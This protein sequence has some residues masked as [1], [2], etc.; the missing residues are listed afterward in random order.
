MRQQ[1][2]VRLSTETRQAEIIGA[3]LQLAAERSPAL[4]TTGDIAKA[5]S[6]TQG[7]V[8]R[9]FPTKDAIWL[10]VIDWV[11][12]NLLDSLEA[13]AQNAATPLAGLQ[14]VF[15]AHIGFVMQYPGVP[16]LI[17]SELQQPDD[18]PMKISVRS[19]LERYRQLL[20]RLLNDAETT[21]QID[22]EIDK[23]AAGM[24]FI[25]SVQGLVM[26]SMLS[27]GALNMKTAA[28][29]VFVLYLNALRG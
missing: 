16:R 8:F 21:G 4:I 11:E 13:A 1:T 26:Q 14:A 10:A 3:V 5:V 15:M 23:G 25:G 12:S 20:T 29:R 28:E 17:F 9:H 27:N 2:R 22:P 6:L 24:L 7:A 18:T 19:I